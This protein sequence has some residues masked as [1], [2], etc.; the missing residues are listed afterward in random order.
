MNNNLIKDIDISAFSKLKSSG[1]SLDLSNNKINT[2]NLSGRFKDNKNLIELNVM[3][4]PLKSFSFQLEY[5]TDFGVITH[6]PTEIESVD[7]SCNNKRKTCHSS[8]VII[9]SK[10][11]KNVRMFNASRND[12]YHVLEFH[13][14]F[15][16]LNT[17]MEILDLSLAWDLYNLNE[18]VQLRH[19]NLS[20]SNIGTIRANA[21]ENQL[22]LLSLDLSFNYLTRVD[23]KITPTLS[24]L[25]LDG[26][27]L[28]TIDLN[29]TRELRS[30]DS[31]A[32]KLKLNQFDCIYS[33]KFPNPLNWKKLHLVNDII[34]EGNKVN[35]FY[36]T[37]RAESTSLKPSGGEVQDLNSI[38]TRKNGMFNPCSHLSKGTSIFLL[39]AK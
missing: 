19:L 33:E 6:L 20:H 26:N 29:V 15:R 5:F 23:F 12:K 30:F 22:H 35:G 21:F 4:N 7:I 31:L 27:Q 36:C 18:L 3:G 39:Y 9:N 25:N 13:Q 10:N 14:L 32:I 34:A 24:S 17:K 28:I 1:L 8:N 16:G 38:S 11:L 37:S 2:E